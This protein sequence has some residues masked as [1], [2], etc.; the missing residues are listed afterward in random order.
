MVLVRPDRALSIH[1]PPLSQKYYSQIGRNTLSRFGEIQS[2]IFEKYWERFL[3]KDFFHSPELSVAA[4]GG[5]DRALSIH[6]TSDLAKFL[7]MGKRF[8]L[9]I[10]SDDDDD[11][12][13]DSVDDDDD[14]VDNDN[15]NND[16]GDD[17]DDNLD[18]AKQKSMLPAPIVSQIL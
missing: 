2:A 3:G 1:T 14:D 15:V 17:D 12:V 10:P 18:A 9:Q 6:A 11:K 5:R 13:V 16:D 8:L 4:A 7:S